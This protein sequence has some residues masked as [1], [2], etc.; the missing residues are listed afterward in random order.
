M[1]VIS[2]DGQSFIIGGRKVWIVGGAIHYARVPHQL[3]RDR[4]RAAKQAGINCIDT[5]VFWNLHEIK[6]GKFCFEGDLD[7]RQFIQTVAA[8][9][10]YCILRP[11]PY[12]GSGWDFGGLPAWLHRLP[13]IKLRQSNGLFLEASAR[14]LGAVLDQVKDLQVTNSSVDGPIILMGAENRWFCDNP[15]QAQSYLLEICRYLREN[16]C[17]V[18][19]ID[20]NNLW[21]TVE[22]AIACWSGDDHLAA[23]LRQ[24]RQ[25]QPH[26]PRLI[27]EYESESSN[28]WGSPH[29]Q[30]VDAATHLSRMASILAVGAQY[31]VSMFHGGTNHGF[32]A[33]RAA[34]VPNGFTTTTH[35]CESP[36]AEGGWRGPKYLATK[37]ICTFAS[38]F[39]QLFAHLHPSNQHAAIAINQNPHG[40]SVIH[41]SGSQGQVVFLFKNKKDKTTETQIML[42]NG[43]ILPVSIGP[44]PVAWLALE[45]DL[46]GIATLNYTNLR[47]WAFLDR[48]LLVLFGP[49]GTQGLVCINGAQ[50]RVKVPTGRTPAIEHHEDLVVA[51]LNLAQVDAAYLG[52]NGLM[53]GADGID[54]DDQPIA[55]TG[56]PNVT[57]VTSDGKTGRHKTVKVTRIEAPPLQAWEQATVDQM[58]SGE[59]PM[60]K[61][62][63]GPSSLEKLG[64]DYGYGWY[65]LSVKSQSS[66]GHVLAPESA[67][68]LHLYQKGKLAAI[69]GHGPAA[70]GDPMKLKV[71]GTMVALSDNLG[72]LSDG[73]AMGESKGLFG[74]L[75]AVKRATLGRAQIVKEKSPDLFALNGFFPFAH[76]TPPPVSDALVWQ[77]KPKDK[78]PLVVD[79]D[80]L[81]WRAML[82]VNDQPVGAYDP[83]QNGGFVRFT[84]HVGHTLNRKPN[85]L[86]LVALGQHTQREL[87]GLAVSKH[88]RVYQATANLTDRAS[89]AFAP[90][91][92]P[93]RTDFV[94]ISKQSAAQPCWYRCRFRV[95]RVDVPLW[96]EPIGMTK[97]QLYINGH[98]AGRYFVTTPTGQPVGPQTRYY[99]PEPWLITGA[100]NELL[101]FDEH[102]KNPHKCRLVYNTKGPWDK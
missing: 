50:L 19:I 94:A 11:G 32:F 97:G 13:G 60:F 74:H 21:S 65:R 39:S 90:W 33:G 29:V 76:N 59:S 9:G 99:L 10:L 55:L 26:A 91:T 82:L 14:Y 83:Q 4:I 51:V 49:A 24:L 5:Y 18:P 79:I 36:L 7:L 63:D 23:D 8:E 48:Q 54:G 77:V 20:C 89:W 6:P 73:W 84:L 15:V 78:H 66:S 41:Q 53:V 92:P 56:W 35:D 3:W 40:I 47:P 95:T 80:Q 46:G 16:G 52:P 85:Q 34:A 25:V 45:T 71:T 101:L 22:G 62:I 37:R 58:I 75:Y 61:A 102:G 88:L 31:N 2:Y 30:L 100:T 69:L 28:H 64:C 98:N 67:D 27:V 17:T 12:V 44:E 87:N 96:F 70:H 86:K 68:R 42:P 1:A 38:Q 57:T 43:L 93:E 81:P 72:R